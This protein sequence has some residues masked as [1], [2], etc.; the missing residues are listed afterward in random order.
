MLKE[1]PNY[2]DVKMCCLNTGAKSFGNVFTKKIDDIRLSDSYLKVKE[3]CSTNKPTEHC[4][5]CS[6][7]ELT[8]IL[9]HVGI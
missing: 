2:G 8:P 9:S 6:Y 7:K 1:A 4:K 3:G 5:N